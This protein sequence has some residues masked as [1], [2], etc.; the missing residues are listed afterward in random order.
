ML[1]RSMSRRHLLRC[2]GAAMLALPV[3]GLAACGATAA[4]TVAT[5]SQ[6]GSRATTPTVSQASSGRQA[7]S[8]T[9]G[10][11]ATVS[12]AAAAQSAAPGTVQLTYMCDIG[13]PYTN[14]AQH[15]ADTFP[16]T[17]PGVTV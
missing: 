16:A 3:V 11:T 17:H 2:T 13:S 1:Q 12:K 8:T 9:S 4:V 5:S 10:T 6:A 7:S 15:W 14:V